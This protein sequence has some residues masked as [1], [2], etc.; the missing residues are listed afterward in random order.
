MVVKIQRNASCFIINHHALLGSNMPLVLSSEK[1]AEQPG[2]LQGALLGADQ[3][4]LRRPGAPAQGCNPPRPREPSPAFPVGGPPFAPQGR[5]APTT[6][7]SQ[8][9]YADGH[10]P[11]TQRSR[12]IGPAAEHTC[13]AGPRGQLPSRPGGERVPRRLWETPGPQLHG[14][15]RPETRQP[16]RDLHPNS[17]ASPRVGQ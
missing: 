9:R 15:R 1:R 11:S 4:R 10:R 17:R 13:V 8:P 5:E 6:G 3:N 16:R 12:A 14:K 2:L 7:S